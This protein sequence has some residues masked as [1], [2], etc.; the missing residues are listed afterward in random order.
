MSRPSPN[1]VPT[2]VEAR[3]DTGDEDPLTEDDYRRQDTW[4]G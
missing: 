3:P 2:G 1:K 4:R